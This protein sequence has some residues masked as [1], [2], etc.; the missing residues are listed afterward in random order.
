MHN[1]LG[2]SSFFRFSLVSDAQSL[3]KT[4]VSWFINFMLSFLLDITESKLAGHL[5]MDNRLVSP[6]VL[7]PVFINSYP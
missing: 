2:S 4:I 7:R 1:A 6:P 3:S 5:I